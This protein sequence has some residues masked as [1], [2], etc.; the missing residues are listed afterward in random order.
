MDLP[1]R[2]AVSFCRI[3]SGGCGVRVTID[4]QDRLV[5]V[6]G[7]KD[8]GLTNGYACFKGL[9][10]PEAHNHPDRILHA[11]K[12]AP[13]GA[14]KRIPLEQAL[15][16]IAAKLKKLIDADGPDSV[17]VFCGNG[18]MPNSTAYPMHRSFLGAIGSR[19][20]YSTLTI[21]QSAKMVSFGR[22]GAWA[23]GAI[24]FDDMDVL[25]MF[26]A[27][28]LVSHAASG[29]LGF[30]PVRQLKHA[31]A[32]GLK[33]IVVDPRRTETG[34][35]ADLVLQPYPAQDAAIAAGLLRMILSEGWHDPAFCARYV[36]ADR[37]AALST[38]VEPFT[39]EMV[40]RRAGLEPG[41]LRQVAE[42]FA[43]DGRVG[44]AYASTGPNMTAFS[45]V[46]QHLVEVLNVVCGRF[47]RAGDP[48]KRSNV[49][50]PFVERRA[51]VIPACRAWEQEPP[52]RIRG[53]GSLFGER[54]SST[55]P[56]E[57][58][59]P[60]PGRVRALLVDGGNPALSLPDQRKTA[61]ALGALDLLVCIDPWMTPTSQLAHYILPPRMQFEHADVL[62]DIPGFDFWPGS[63]NQYT[64]AIVPPPAGSD[65]AEDW[66]IFWAL[67]KRLGKAID[68]AGKG[69][70]SVETEPTTDDVLTHRLQ[71]AQ[72]ELE[73][74][75]QAP[76]GMHIPVEFGVVQAPASGDTATFDVMPADVAHELAEFL[77]RMDEASRLTR[78]GHTYSYVMSTRR[79]R[80]LF[81]STGTKLASVRKRTPYNPAYL[82]PVDLKKL[83][84]KPGDLLELKTSHGRAVVIAAEDDAVR[85]G[86]VSTSHGWGDLPDTNTP[87]DQAG[88]CVNL[89]IDSEHHVETINAMPHFSGVPVD[90]VPLR[91]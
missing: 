26:G 77:E 56:D 82:N 5:S 78:D 81:N 30:D 36:G 24:E 68:Y 21:D 15:D 55:L 8:N 19:Q 88:T 16:E 34:H 83:G 85:P 39:E 47:P 74:L 29:L 23:G 89:L 59:T 25:L 46:A 14:F 9:Q 37:M 57:I 18:S 87:P 79:L 2:E 73:I 10:A 40:E 45:N 27:N 13:D 49:Q 58:L 54:L 67:A 63:W 76:H 69:P 75:K 52:S 44:I 71:G 84:V 43:R 90:I 7:D 70:L 86:V 42:M 6:R 20:Y 61:K 65:T 1:M 33:L 31:K 12:R 32:R 91:A 28:P 4:A 62:F 72:G 80:D 60:G 50:H 22:L 41:Q 48:L 11:L 17:A 51:Q 53:V 35:F 38:A 64:P 3:C 66:Y